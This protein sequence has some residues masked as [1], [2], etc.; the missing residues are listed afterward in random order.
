MKQLLLILTLFFS[1]LASAQL[2]K[3][4]K[5]KPNPPRLVNDYASALTAQQA[6][7]LEAKLV[8]YDKR[9]SNQIT[10]VLVNELEGKSVEDAAMDIGRN[11]GVGNKD[12]NNG[13][14]ILA[15]IKDRKITIQ[16][17]YGL[18]GAVPDLTAK[19]IIDS[20]IKP[21]FKAGNYYRGIDESVDDII[22]AAEGRYTA[23]AGYGKKKKGLPIGTIIIIIIILIVIFGSS[24]G[25]GTYVSRGGWTGW[26]GGGGG[27]G[28]SGGGGSSGGG[29]FGGFGGGSF[30]GG[31][32]S[33][34]W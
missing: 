28:W 33:G 6:E 23:P 15:A 14:V 30:G 32:A 16:V 21:N 20:R 4:I 31:G 3:I 8:Q 24:A 22:K 17:G 25:N 18:E 13:V 1:T 10:V 12:F 27:S 29:G 11:W 2:E 19:T 9:T 34:D 7:A 5:N 26:T